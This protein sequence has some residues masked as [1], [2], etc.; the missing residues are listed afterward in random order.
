MAGEVGFAVLAPEDLVR[1]EIDVV[2]KPHPGLAP[3]T[4]TR[5]RGSVGFALAPLKRF[6]KI[7]ERRGEGGV[8]VKLLPLFF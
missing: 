4:D 3:G 2:R 8:D 1:V 7:T 5:R 6:S